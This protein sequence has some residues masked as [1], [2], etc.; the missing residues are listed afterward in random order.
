MKLLKNEISKIINEDMNLRNYINPE[1]EKAF[2]MNEQQLQEATEVANLPSSQIFTVF[3]KK[4]LN[5]L[6]PVFQKNK[7]TAMRAISPLVNDPE[8]QF[9]KYDT[10]FE[11]YYIGEY[12]E[13]NGIILGSNKPEFVCNLSELKE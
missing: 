5:Y 13:S 2:K 3:D 7:G 8:H 6:P 4:G 11:L 10:D 1:T 9:G 12:C